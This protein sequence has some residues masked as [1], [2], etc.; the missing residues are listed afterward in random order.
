M[1]IPTPFDLDF[2]TFLK[3]FNPYQKLDVSDFFTPNF[4][5]FLEDNQ[6]DFLT[7]QP[8]ENLPLFKHSDIISTIQYNKS[9][10]GLIMLQNGIIPIGCYLWS[11]LVIEES[12]QRKGLGRELI[13]N[14]FTLDGFNPV[15]NLDTAAYSPAGYA[16]HKSA[17]NSFR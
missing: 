4:H 10:Y 7:E 9:E 8:F 5:E 6:E 2:D 14:R 16:A 3:G 1:T 11:T 17:W 12:W 13:I 15:W